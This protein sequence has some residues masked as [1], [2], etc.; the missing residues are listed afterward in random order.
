[1]K[2]WVGMSERTRLIIK[3]VIIT[4]SVYL[5]FRFILPLILPFIFSLLLAYI[6]RPISEFLYK[7]VKL[8]RIVGG[9]VS[10][11]LLV[12]VISVGLFY[13][14]NIL[15]QQAITF[16][17]NIPA[18]LTILAGKLDNICSSCDEILGLTAGS[19]RAL[20]DDNM[21]NMVNRIRTQAI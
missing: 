21:I 2:F 19:V 16:A 7:K 5:S 6:V 14:G 15:V 13:L 11:I 17:K 9:S 8:P 4:L 10:L 18:Y 3:V 12:I 1:M 20:L